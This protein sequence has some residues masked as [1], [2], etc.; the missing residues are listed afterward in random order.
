M[1]EKHY[2]IRAVKDWLTEYAATE[3]EIDDEIERLEEMAASIESI[4]AQA[5]ADMPRAPSRPQHRI[6]D[7]IGRK[8]E[9][10]QKIRGMIAAQSEKRGRIEEVLSHLRKPEEKTVIRAHYIDGHRW[11]KVRDVL[12]G[13]KG[14]YEDKLDSYLRRVHRV[15]ESALI[16]MARYIE[17]SGGAPIINP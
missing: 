17:E 11:P 9:L 2:D 12:F 14:D 6:D 7:M 4:G 5:I 15:H 16:N 3:R 10:D 8:D 1:D 13:R